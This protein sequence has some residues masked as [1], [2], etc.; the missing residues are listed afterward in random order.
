M[1]AYIKNAIRY[2]GIALALPVGIICGLSDSLLLSWVGKDFVSAA[3]LMVILTM[4]LAINL[5]YQPVSTIP[6]ALNKVSVPGIADVLLIV[7]N[8]A[9]AL[10]L[11]QKFGMGLYGIAI[12]GG[13]TLIIRNI[14]FSTLYASHILKRHPLTFTNQI[15]TPISAVLMVT[16]IGRMLTF[17]Y[18]PTNMLGIGLTALLITIIYLPIVY[19]LYLK[20]KERLHLRSV[21]MKLRR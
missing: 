15:I 20:S 16:A 6:Y 1:V 8:V 2:L 7:F 11:S 9:L 17:A 18:Q 12:A 3:T 14:I 19:V 10:L 5:S 13:I 21:L 4:P